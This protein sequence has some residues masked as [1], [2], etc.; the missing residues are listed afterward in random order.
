M[1]TTLAVGPM[2]MRLQDVRVGA[3]IVYESKLHTSNPKVYMKAADDMIIALDTG[4][5][6]R[7]HKDSSPVVV[8]HMLSCTINAP[9]M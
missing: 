8:V 5:Q 9:G 3:L 7:I 1:K 2:G 6:Y 4:S